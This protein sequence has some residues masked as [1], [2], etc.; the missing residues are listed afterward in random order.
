[1]T[2]HSKVLASLSAVSTGLLLTAVVTVTASDPR[3]AFEG[4]WR[5]EE[6]V[7][8]GPA[9][10][11]TFR[12]GATLA[13]FHGRHYSRV[14]VHAEGARAVLKDPATASADELRA[15]WGPFVGEAG[16]F[17]VSGTNVLTMQAIVAKNPAAMMNGATSVYTYQRS[18]DALTLTQVR[19]PLGPSPAPVTIKLVRVE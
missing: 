9:Q 2:K 16:T 4:V 5:T 3:P 11:Q 6:V 18:G 14:E 12:P 8:A 15:V 1:M 10:Q 17:E 19:T 7:V 13:I